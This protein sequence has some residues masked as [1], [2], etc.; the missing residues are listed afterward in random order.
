MIGVM[1]GFLADFDLYF[2]KLFDGLRHDS[3]DP[4]VWGEKALAHYAKLRID[5]NTKRLVFSDGLDI[6]EAFRLHAHF[7][8][9]VQLGFGIGTHLSN[10]MGLEPLNVVMKLTRCNGQPVAKLSDSPGKTLC[11]DETFLA[12]LRQVFKVDS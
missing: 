3:G 5:P 7:G 10:D 12:Y 9:R 1:D 2:A 4:V 8:D 11:D 6:D